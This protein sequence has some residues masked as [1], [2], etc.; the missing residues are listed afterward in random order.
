[1]VKYKTIH[2]GV[3]L[4]RELLKREI[5]QR[6]FAS[7]IGMPPPVL[8]DIINQR[9]NI[10][11]DIAVLLE[12]A[13]YINASFWLSIQNDRDIEIA[14]G[15]SDYN[16]KANIID[17]WTVIQW[18]CNTS[19]IQKYIDRVLWSN[20]N[21]KIDAILAFFNVETVDDLCDTHNLMF[22]K[23]PFYVYEDIFRRKDLFSLYHIALHLNVIFKQQIGIFNKNNY[24]SIVNNINTI[25]YENNNTMSRVTNILTQNGIKPFF[26]NNIKDTT[27][28][29]FSFWLDNTPIVVIIIPEM[30]I[31]ILA[32]SLLH[33]LYH[34]YK[35]HDNIKKD[36]MCISIKGHLNTLQEKKTNDYVT[37]QLFPTIE[38]QLF[39][40]KIQHKT[41]YKILELINVYA[42]QH[43]INPAIVLQKIKLDSNDKYSDI[44][45]ERTIK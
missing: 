22:E 32:F 15:K 44:K 30:E 38:W 45:I 18:Y 43:L 31:D 2:P 19:Y 12:K 34:I 40:S 7:L 28:E 1:M 23:Y 17:N 3:I 42:Q 35:C 13:L 36:S 4:K 16:K 39:K 10:T 26:I 37:E 14:R 5:S 29:G 9:R 20:M 33:E 21:Q 41:N 24:K 6:D 11:P 27:I 25:L 8:N